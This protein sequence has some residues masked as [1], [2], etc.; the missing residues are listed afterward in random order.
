MQLSDIP[1]M[2]PDDIYAARV[3]IAARIHD[4]RRLVR[5]LESD[6]CTRPQGNALRAR[7]DAAESALLA[8]T[9]PR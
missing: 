7:A 5:A 2:A 9:R 4:A 8:V 3:K 1:G 6:I